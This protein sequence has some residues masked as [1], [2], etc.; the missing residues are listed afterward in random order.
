MLQVSIS[1]FSP[2]FTTERRL[3]LDCDA[4][5]ASCSGGSNQKQQLED[6]LPPHFLITCFDEKDTE[7]RDV[8]ILPTTTW[9]QMQECITDAFGAQAIF[10]YDDGSSVDLPVRVLSVLHWL[11][12]DALAAKDYRDLVGAQR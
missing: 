5:D 10:A 1:V 7:L 3:S 4:D 12:P 2:R 6:Q 8:K 9:P 11:Q